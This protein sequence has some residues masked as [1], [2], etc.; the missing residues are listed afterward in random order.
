[1]PY[2][3]AGIIQKI[4]CIRFCVKVTSNKAS[5]ALSSGQSLLPKRQHTLSF[6]H[7]PWKQLMLIPSEL[8]QSLAERNRLWEHSRAT[9]P[10]FSLWH[11]GK[12]IMV[13]V[14]VRG[15]IIL[16]SVCQNLWVA[17]ALLRENLADAAV[18]LLKVEQLPCRS[19]DACTLLHCSHVQCVCYCPFS[20]AE[21]S[22][23]KPWQ[24]SV[25]FCLSNLCH[26]LV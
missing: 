2:P 23:C 10:L 11:I 13:F 17:S 8:L 25:S 22:H 14:P 18:V 19:D 12:Q 5:K 15:F 1:M 4:R 3:Q 21:I 24:E 9:G 26:L 6:T 7:L 20:W 16:H